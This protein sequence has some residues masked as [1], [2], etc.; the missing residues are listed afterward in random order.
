MPNE[1]KTYKVGKKVA[2]VPADKAAGFLELYPDAVEVKSFTVGKDTADVPLDKLESFLELYPDAKPLE[3]GKQQA[4]P[5]V[6]GGGGLDLNTT[7]TQPKQPSQ[8]G[9]SNIASKIGKPI[10]PIAPSQEISPSTKKV[11]DAKHNQPAMPSVQD[12]IQLPPLEQALGNGDKHALAPEA[13]INAA[14]ESL[15]MSPYSGQMRYNPLKDLNRRKEELAAIDN[16]DAKAK[17][18]KDLWGDI[19]EFY[20]NENKE[21]E[22]LVAQRAPEVEQQLSVFNQITAELERPD[23]PEEQ[24]QVLMGQH[25]ELANALEQSSAELQGIEEQY[26]VNT[27]TAAQMIK[28]SSV[29]RYNETSPLGYAGQSLWNSTIPAL[30]ETAGAALEIVG[31]PSGNPTLTN[32][33]TGKMVNP[34]PVQQLGTFLITGGEVLKGTAESTDAQKIFT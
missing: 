3:L 22:N 14:P 29:L 4:A 15:E 2:D 1:T 32:P 25:E 5:F 13:K 8:F 10:E 9:I 21:I 27:R 11:Q 6:G 30:L 16:P 17:G 26:K 34:T 20:A 24:R 31:N 19:T 23:L 12:G 18:T 33:E 28:G 7:P